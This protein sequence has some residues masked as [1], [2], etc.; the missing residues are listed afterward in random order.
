MKRIKLNSY[1][2]FTSLP[3]EELKHIM[4]GSG[5]DGSG[6]GSGN[7]SGF[8][9]CTLGSGENDYSF[10]NKVKS[11][12]ECMAMC[13]ADCLAYP[14]CTL[15]VPYSYGGSGYAQSIGFEVTM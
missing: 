2:S 8:C 10:H 13:K 14:G 3:M 11:E 12:E 5:D 7:H 6:P 9:T 4:G 1:H 15:P